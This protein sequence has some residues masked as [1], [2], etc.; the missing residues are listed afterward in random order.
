MKWRAL[1][2]LLLTALVV[3][4]CSGKIVV[5]KYNPSNGDLGGIPFR[6][7]ESWEEYYT[8]TTIKT[9][10]VISKLCTQKL[11]TRAV[12]NIPSNDLYVISYKA[13]NGLFGW[14]ESRK[15]SVALHENGTLASVNAESTPV[16]P[17]EWA[18]V[19][20]IV[21]GLPMFVP[22]QTSEEAAPLIPNG[23]TAKELA[24]QEEKPPPPLCTGDPYSLGRCKIEDG[25][26][27]EEKKKTPLN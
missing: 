23:L 24:Q 26:C 20:Q 3:A 6:V 16:S 25:K 15:L 13:E 17:K 12:E 4:G 8:F 10:G 14:L 19:A 21:A 1:A 18:E 22:T 9:N 27:V 2:P 11:R 5:K 7:A